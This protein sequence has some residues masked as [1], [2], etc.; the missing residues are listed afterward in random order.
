MAP[1]STQAPDH[2]VIMLQA[3]NEVSSGTLINGIES[4]IG[5]WGQ[6]SP[7]VELRLKV[8]FR[9]LDE[10]GDELGYAHFIVHM[11][12]NETQNSPEPNI[13]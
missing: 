2:D 13:D 9:S 12:F 3:S 6:N 10:A 7:T 4:H 5:G 11:A 8:D 1:S